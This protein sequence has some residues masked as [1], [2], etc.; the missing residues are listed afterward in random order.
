MWSFTLFA[1]L[2]YEPVEPFQLHCA[3]SEV[4]LVKLAILTIQTISTN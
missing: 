4:E 3:V 2:T 1:G